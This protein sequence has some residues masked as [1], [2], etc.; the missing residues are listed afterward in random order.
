MS[1]LQKV[2]DDTR[3]RRIEYENIHGGDSDSDSNENLSESGSHYSKS[4]SDTD[5][6]EE[7][8]NEPL[9]R[10]IKPESQFPKRK[11]KIC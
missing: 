1:T 3:R 10:L 11:R 8:D 4:S 6:N 9:A 7:S 2:L 5:S